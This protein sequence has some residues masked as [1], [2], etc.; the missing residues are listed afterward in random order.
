MKIIDKLISDGIIEES[1]KWGTIIGCCPREY[2]LEDTPIM[3][4]C[5]ED[6]C[7]ECWSREVEE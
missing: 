4:W 7:K 1:D 3:S 6:K 2:G 5:N